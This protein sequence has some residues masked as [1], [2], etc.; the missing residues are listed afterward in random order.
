VAP[1]G[2]AA[3]AGL[4]ESAQ[5]QSTTVRFVVDSW[6]SYDITGLADDA[7]APPGHRLSLKEQNDSSMAIDLALARNLVLQASVTAT[8]NQDRETA[9][10]Y[11]FQRV[12]PATT[13]IIRGLEDLCQP[14]WTIPF[15][16]SVGGA[17]AF[18][19]S[20]GRSKWSVNHWL[21]IPKLY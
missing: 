14:L 20:Q 18:F 3:P 6:F 2:V 17:Q 5:Q 4:L 9:A 8:G 19:A 10:K 12:K 13:V 16:E 11:V 1:G 15:L 7:G 21:V